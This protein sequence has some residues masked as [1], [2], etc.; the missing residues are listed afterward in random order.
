MSAINALL[1]Q[2]TRA[3]EAGD[4]AALA[5]LFAE[6]GIYHDGFYGPFQGRA[7]I[8]DM[9][10]NHFH[11]HARDLVWHMSDAIR[12]GDLGYAS[13]RFGYTSTLPGHEGRRVVFT[14]MAR[15]R[16][17]DDLIQRYDEIFDQGIGLVQIGFSPE[18]I[19]RRLEKA[20]RAL[21]DAP[22][23]APFLQA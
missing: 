14:G 9:L 1:Q 8:A 16:F 6:D 4:G 5:A 15:L 23:S 21:R 20:A 12:V 13:Y 11:A 3:V 18:R 7:A 22:L 17:S 10:E 2:F 19:A